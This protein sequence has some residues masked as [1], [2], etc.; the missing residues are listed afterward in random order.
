MVFLIVTTIVVGGSFLIPP[1]YT[2]QAAIMI[3]LGR[4]F[5]YREP[6]G[7]SDERA[8]FSLAEMVNSEV[9]ILGSRDLAEQVVRQLQV[10]RL[11]PEMLEDPEADPDAVFA[12]AVAR[13]RDSLVVMDVLES[14]VIRIT[15]DHADRHIAADALNVFIEWSKTK[16]LDVFGEPKT[17]FISDQLASYEARLSASEDTLETFRRTHGVYSLAEQKSLLLNQRVMLDTELNTVRFRISELEHRLSMLNGKSVSAEAA[18][19]PPRLTEDRESL[20]GRRGALG[21]ELQ[22]IEIRLAEIQQQLLIIRDRGL[23]ENDTI[24]PIPG[25]ER[26]RSI[27][28]AFSRLLD[29]QLRERELLRNFDEEN[30]QVIGV[31]GE[32]EV[33][34]RFLKVQGAFVQATIERTYRDEFEGLVARRASAR[35]QIKAVDALIQAY[36][37]RQTLDELAPLGARR[38]TIRQEIAEL[39]EEISTLHENEKQHRRLERRVTLD[40]RSY[41]AF[42]D[43][44]D[45]ARIMEEL[46]KQK[47][48]NIAVIELATPPIESNGLSMKLRAVLGAFVG[49][50]AGAAAAVFLDLAAAPA[51]SSHRVSSRRTKHPEE[52]PE[53]R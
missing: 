20:A 2:A 33:V 24:T 52:G 3:K 44:A 22:Q 19:P 43:V 49:L 31:R 38:T 40:E 9:E 47:M 27:D 4:E 12:A 18:E 29:L 41:N 35:D 42:V 53:K 32:I 15:F 23:V 48:I 51:V 39:D 50:F 11:Y 36:E 1:M 37:V 10:Q 26:T 17:G 21:T 7:N 45:E 14:S 28:Q 6:A 30:R 25:I 8:I 5:Y 13:F 46:D 34:Q 16:H